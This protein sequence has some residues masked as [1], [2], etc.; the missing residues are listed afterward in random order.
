MA[1]SVRTGVYLHTI[2]EA[3]SAHP[4]GSHLGRGRNPLDEAAGVDG[5]KVGAVGGEAGRGG[6]HAG[7]LARARRRRRQVTVDAS[8]LR[9]TQGAR[10]SDAEANE[11]MRRSNC[12]L[13][14][15]FA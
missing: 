10:S 7:F 14:H 5:G 12:A 8:K 6:A 13:W 15:V 1:R 9:K 2:K 4:P 3:V 11:S